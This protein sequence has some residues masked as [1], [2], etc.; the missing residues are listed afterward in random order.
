MR[1]T[2]PT[3]VVRCDGTSSKVIEDSVVVEEPLE[4]RVNNQAIGVT[5]RTPGDDFDLAVGL[6][7]TAGIVQRFAEISTIAYWPDEQDPELRNIVTISLVD[8]TRSV[9]SSRTR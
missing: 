8:T 1:D 7:R 4:V 2:Q 5:M 3:R 6:M 9:Q